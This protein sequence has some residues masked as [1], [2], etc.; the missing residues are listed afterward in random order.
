MAPIRI[1][2]L[3]TCHN[4][5][6]TTVKCLENL[7]HQDLTEEMEM[8]VL[9]VDDGC[10]DGTASEVRSRFPRVRILPGSGN[11]FWCG[12]MRLAFSE[13]V[14]TPQDYYLWL[15]DD[16]M[17]YSHAIQ[18]LLSA[19]VTVRREQ[20]RDSI[21]VGATCDS[22]TGKR[23]YTGMIRTS[24][25]KLLD[26]QSVDPSDTP[27]SC[28][29]MHG[30]CVLI[31]RPVTQGIGIIGDFQ[32]HFGDIDYGLRA[33]RA[34]FGCFLAP[35]IVG[36][37]SWNAAHVAAPEVDPRLRLRERIRIMCSPKRCPPRDWLR[38]VRTHTGLAWPYYFAKPWL[39][40]FF[41]RLMHPK[42]TVRET[43]KSMQRIL[44]NAN[45]RD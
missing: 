14:K 40:V 23:T 5:C 4:R 26:F 32:H 2:V 24:R 45:L 41:P 19:A 21:I 18:S 22:R 28:D 30:N 35:R 16:T 1:A 6:A 29:T 10:S 11:L 27:R 12:G 31:P 7:H 20:G 37:C 33:T 42:K 36:E 3:M 44:R 25:W 8:S 38:F 34:G 39:S 15:N 43:M 17:L 9:L 13:A